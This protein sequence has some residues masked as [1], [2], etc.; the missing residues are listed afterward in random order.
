MQTLEIVIFAV[1]A[2]VV[3]YQL[4]AVLGRRIGRQPG[5]TPASATTPALA[6][7]EV[8]AIEGP[9]VEL[10]GLA[11]IKGRDAD[12]DPEKFL[13]GSRNAYESIVRAFA[14]GDRE[15]LKP[16]V[17]AHVMAGFEAAMAKREGEGRTDSA[18]FSQ[19]PRADVEAAEVD[20][21]IARIRVRFLAEFRSRAT[22]PEG[23]SVDDRRTAEVWSFE[24]DLKSRD[25]NWT[26]VR[27]DAAEA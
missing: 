10:G 24:R 2:A 5:E 8:P 16:L 13:V 22:G 19:Q 27:V 3:L 26:L 7:G 25:P 6:K 17:S 11:A 18:E 4:Y 12:F 20:G 23:E 9:A 15:A 1:L 21:D 14:S